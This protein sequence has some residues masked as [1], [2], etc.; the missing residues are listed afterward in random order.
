MMDYFCH[1]MKKKSQAAVPLSET[2]KASRPLYKIFTAVPPSYDL[3]N[4]LFT[5]RMD[6]RWRIK[7]AHECL[8]DHPLRV[9]DLCTGTG[10]L[11]VR[12]AKMTEGKAGI[13]GYDYSQ[14]MLDLAT[15]KADRAGFGNIR[16]IQG[17]AAAMPF[18][19]GYF[20]A[21]GIAFAFRNLTFKNHDTANFLREI[22]R[23]L[24]PGGRFVIIESSQP[25]RGW[26]RRL[27]RAW[28]R[29][30]VYPVG[31]LVSGNKGAYKY[32]AHSV[33]N[34]YQPEEICDLLRTYGF[35]EVTFKRLTGGVSALHVAV[36]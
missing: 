5:L 8:A 22:H 2:Q 18:T 35:S 25:Q 11:A 9:M 10:D 21:I 30:F 6:E 26:L 7:A 15:K 16:F 33:I 12:L 1:I 28:T 34:Y 27:F 23:V 3:I 29:Y 13:T 17:D 24:K 36:K 32:L 20:D 4:R 19:D 14:P 31:S